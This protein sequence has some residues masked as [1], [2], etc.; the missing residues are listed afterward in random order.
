MKHI[1]LK[2][3]GLLALIMS[4]GAATSGH[5][6]T[7]LLS[8]QSSDY[9]ATTG[10]WSDSSGNGDDAF[11]GGAFPT[12]VANSTPNGSSAVDFTG[13]LQSLQL[14]NP[15]AAQDVTI[16]AYILPSAN[17]SA[18]GDRGAIISGGGGGF[19]YGITDFAKYGN[20]EQDALRT[21]EEDLGA[22][23]SSVSTSAYSVVDVSE[24]L[25][26]GGT[27]RLNG[28]DDGSLLASAAGTT[29][30][31]TTIGSQDTGS[32]FFSGD[33]AAIEVYSGTMTDAQR[34][35]IEGDLIATYATST[36]EP[37]TWALLL[38]GLGLLA[39]LRRF[40]MAGQV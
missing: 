40:R 9:N 10:V 8:L 30:F 36:P 23:T 20:S 35:V 19:E 37:S 4:V 31:L 34:A 13:T 38:G 18:S 14:L 33:I 2:I 15:I 21:S 17:Q 12:L 22:S 26:L 7:L 3:T 16:F 28:V 27:Y 11:A 24:S 29:K 5:A 39:L 6:Q 1:N 25:T 32:E